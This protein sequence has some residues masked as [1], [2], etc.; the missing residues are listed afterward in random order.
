MRQGRRGARSGR[1][2]EPASVSETEANACPLLRERS[3][4]SRC[5]A[6]ARNPATVATAADTRRRGHELHCANPFHEV[7][8]EPNCV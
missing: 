7:R 6:A 3:R 4:R 1:D 2:G 8:A 5:R